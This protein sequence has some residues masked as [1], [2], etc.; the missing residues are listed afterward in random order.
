MI[1]ANVT[2]HSV[3]IQLHSTDSVKAL[4]LTLLECIQLDE[5]SY[6]FHYFLWH[7]TGKVTKI[8]T[9]TSVKT[10]VCAILV[11]DIVWL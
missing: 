10:V 8:R 6:G 2:Q 7:V 4:V 9:Y 5:D 1:R 3:D 11:F